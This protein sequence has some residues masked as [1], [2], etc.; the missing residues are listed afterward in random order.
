MTEGIEITTSKCSYEEI[1]DRLQIIQD[2]HALSA[3]RPHLRACS[4]LI[5]DPK[6]ID[7]GIFGRFKAGKSSL[8]NLLAG[9]SILPVGVTPVTT[10]VTQLRYGPR[11]QA[12]IHYA[13]GR[14]ER[15]PAESVASCV[16]E[17]ENPKNVKKVASVTVELPSLRAYR[18]L[19]FVDTPGLESVFEHNTETAL[20]WLPEAGLALVSISVDPP[21]SKHDVELIRIL[22]SYTPKIVILLTKVDLVS[23]PEREEIETFIQRELRREFGSEFRVIPISV[24]PSYDCLK[25]VLDRNLLQPLVENH[26]CTRSEILR[27]KLTS[28]LDQAKNYLSLALAAAER[29]DIDRAGLRRQILNE[30]NS[31]E[32][33]RLELQALATQCAGQ[34]RPKIMKRLEELSP[35]IQQCLTQELQDKLSRLRTNLWDLSRAYEEWLAQAIRREMSEISLRESGLFLIPLEKARQTLSHA[36]QGFRDRLTGSIEQALGIR[37]QVEPFEIDFEKPVFPDVAISN[38]FMFNTD[39]LWFVIPMFIFRSWA[40]RHFLKRIP[41]ETEKN[42]SRLASQWTE[43]INAAILKMQRD[44]E[45]Y[46][47]NQ[48]LTIE[49]M[50]SRTQSQAE[51]IRMSLLEVESSAKAISS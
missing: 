32:S 44:A 49:S 48:L 30:K 10:V 27:F 1:I 2:T 23:E 11:E 47:R 42:L 37:F 26:D 33:I 14:T 36:L 3:I 17:A 7:V 21:L 13:E 18:G 51:E 38:L 31:Y 5:E 20:D 29:V 40:D 12:M 46:I 34:T 22:R 8:L 41:F 50:L 15:I 25:T 6:T 45:R 19:Q 28:L 16:S 43:R 9:K 24:R 35:E 4:S 39:L